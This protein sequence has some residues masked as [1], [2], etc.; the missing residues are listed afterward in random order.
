MLRAISSTI[1]FSICH[2]AQ[3]RRY[4]NLL[5]VREIVATNSHDFLYLFLTALV[6]MRCAPNRCRVA[7]FDRSSYHSADIAFL[8][9]GRGSPT[10]SSA[11]PCLIVPCV[12]SIGQFEVD[13]SSDLFLGA[14]KLRHELGVNRYS[15]DFEY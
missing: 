1:P 3:S 5:S 2:V 8:I 13:S 4:I 12:A 15:I 14:K 7:S 10:L 6:I 9:I 11:T